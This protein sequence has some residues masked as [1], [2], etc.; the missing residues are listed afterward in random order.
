M[1][2]TSRERVLAT[3]KNEH[4]DKVPIHHLGF[5]ADSASKILGREVYVGGGIQQWREAN[6]LLEGKD[7]HQK[8]LNR[9]LEDAFQLRLQYL[10]QPCGEG[11][12]MGTDIIS[13]GSDPDTLIGV[14]RN[15][16]GQLCL[17]SAYVDFSGGWD[18]RSRWV[19]RR[20]K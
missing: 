11:L 6:A 16:D 1:D 17:Y 2:M 8:F 20:R 18:V 3:F 15:D 12:L 7:A 10:D 13:L 14:R 9:S 4:T 5:S 19:F